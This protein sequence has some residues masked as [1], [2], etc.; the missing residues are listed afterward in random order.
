[1]SQSLDKRRQLVRWQ[2]SIDIAVAFCQ[3]CREI[4][5]TQ[6]H[7]QG[8]SPPDE[9]WQSLRSAAA[10]NKPNRHLWMAEDRFANGSKTHVHGQRDLTPSAPG[11]ALDF[12]DGYLRHVP[13][14]LA[15][16]LRKTKASRRGYRFGSGSNPAQ[17]RVGHEEL[18]KRA[19]Q[20]HNP[21]ALIGLEFPAEFVEFLRQNF[22]K[23][24]DRRVIDA[25]ECDSRIKSELETFVIRI[26]HLCS[27]TRG[28]TRDMANSRAPACEAG[29]LQSTMY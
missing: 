20:D 14:P 9:P 23:K 13:E 7:L 11:P 3:L 15:D 1:M 10:R 16:R 17:T 8:A 25:D 26:W 29:S 12:G 4:I 6:E 28:F 5:A 19:L 2:C 27:P 24:I 21:D 22:I 18:R